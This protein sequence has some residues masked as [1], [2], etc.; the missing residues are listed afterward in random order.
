M[1]FEANVNPASA[2][3]VPGSAQIPASEVKQQAL[4][5]KQVNPAEVAQR[6]ENSAEDVRQ[7]VDKLNEL[8]QNGKRSLNFQVDN[9]NDRVIV[10]VTDSQTN[11]LVRQ[12]PTE[13][14][15]KLKEYIEGMMGIIFNRSI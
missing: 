3:V 11:E 13:E 9:S 1:A 6:V 15:L 10:Q 14:A 8:M 4:K 2:A 7:A 12:I 5:P